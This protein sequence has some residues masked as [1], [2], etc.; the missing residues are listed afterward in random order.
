VWLAAAALALGACKSDGDGTTL[1]VVSVTSEAPLTDVERLELTVTVVADGGTSKHDQLSYAAHTDGGRAISSSHAVTL[2][3]K[4]ANQPGDVFL[5]LDAY[6]AAGA[7][8]GATDTVGPLHLRAGESVKVTLKPPVTSPDGGTD[9]SDAHDDGV[10]G[11]DGPADLSSAGGTS[12]SAGVGAAGAAGAASPDAG[13]AGAGTTEAGAGQTGAGGTKDGGGDATGGVGGTSAT[14]GAGGT[15]ATGGAGGTASDAGVPA[16]QTSATQ[17]S[18]AGY[19]TCG[20]DRQWGLVTD[21]GPHQACT[22]PAGT[23][24]CTCKTDPVCTALGNACMGANQV[25]CMQDGN[26]C[27][28]VG[29]STPCSTG[30]CGGS[31]GACCTTAACT[32]GT[33]QC[34]SATTLVTCGA[35]VSGC[36]STSSKTCT[37]GTVCEVK[38]QD[39]VDPN[40]AEW[41]MPGATING[42]PDGSPNPQSYTDN[43]DMTVTDNVTGLMWQQPEPVSTYNQ[44]DAIS[45]CANL[46]LA[47][48]D[49]WRLPS[50]IELAS[51]LDLSL[52]ASI[53]GTYFPGTYNSPT[54]TTLVYEKSTSSIYVVDFGGGRITSAP[55]N[56]LNHVRCVR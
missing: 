43:K 2:G 51:L 14:A 6:G 24:K 42:A 13:A 19:Q 37:G 34:G 49:D 48:H 20:A 12:G 36:P 25:G 52:P 21:C 11:G 4:L 31:P 28:Y 26:G 1:V 17:C 27:Y 29:S 41:P 39:C 38:P 22:G 40:W 46:V 16:C 54:W 3:V 33:S 47:G 10:D 55:A 35:L 50:P 15:T 9:A 18:G 8:I 56:S 7:H 44:S 53:N 45:Y 23:A 32:V 5:S 30:L